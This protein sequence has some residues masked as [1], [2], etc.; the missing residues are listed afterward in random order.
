MFDLMVQEIEQVE[1]PATQRS[2]FAGTEQSFDSLFSLCHWG[3]TVLWNKTEDFKWL[4]LGSCSFLG[5]GTVIYA[6]W[7][8]QPKRSSGPEYEEVPLDD[9]ER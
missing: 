6:F 5:A 3:A 9:V 2:T 4:A 1:I 8:K 7:S